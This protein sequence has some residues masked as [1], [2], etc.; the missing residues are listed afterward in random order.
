VRVGI[1]VRFAGLDDFDRRAAVRPHRIDLHLRRGDRHDDDRFDRE[2]GGRIGDALRVVAGRRRNDAACAGGSVDMDH[3]VVG[4][5]Q[6]EREDGLVVLALQEDTVAQPGRQ[7]ARR[8]EFRLAG[9]VVDTGGQDFLQ[10]IVGR[11]G[12]GLGRGTVRVAGKMRKR[13]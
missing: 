10:I 8:F 5:A 4:A 7:I 3:L 6:L 13:Q 1:A 12:H 11:R 9:Y 2:P